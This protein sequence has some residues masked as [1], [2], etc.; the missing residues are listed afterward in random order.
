MRLR[1][2]F[3]KNGVMRF[4]GHLDLMR[5]FQKAVR[6]AGIDITYSE[7]FSPH[8]HMSFAAPLGL[9]LTSDGEYM[10]M[11][12]ESCE[13]AEEVVRRLNLVMADG[14]RVIS[15]VVLPEGAKK[16]MAAVEA[17]DYIVYFK[18]REDFT[19][20]EIEDGISSYFSGRDAINVT[21]QGKKGER[22]IDLK[23]LIYAFSAY[24]DGI[25][26]GPQS[27]PD[28][29]G[30]SGIAPGCCAADFIIGDLCARRGFFLR[31]ST[32]S[33]D[34]IKPELVLEDFYKF[35]GREYDPFNLQIHRVE[36]YMRENDV[37]VPLAGGNT[38]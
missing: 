35:M 8:Q 30:I 23:L 27:G 25:D 22:V 10:D 11:E 17:A 31:L 2:K 32:G 5:Y 19:Q 9:G 24:E 36:T 33:T 13:S 16:A 7:G 37:F 4:V 1:I 14:V 26:S 12:V 20:S 18:H 15:C 3:S 28:T 29:G 38:L 21:K 6:R 34:N